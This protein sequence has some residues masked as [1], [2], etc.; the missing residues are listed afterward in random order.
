MTLQP[1]CRE[2]KAES[3]ANPNKPRR[4]PRTLIDEIELA[5]FLGKSVAWAQRSRWAG[6]GPPY[7]K[8][9]R[10][11]RY[12]LQEVETWIDAQS[13]DNTSQEVA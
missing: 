6:G 13:R 5:A 9:G 3:D 8:I 7:K 11:V 10:H 12:D 2:P 4:I 1:Q